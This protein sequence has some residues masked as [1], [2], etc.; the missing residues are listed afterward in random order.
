MYKFRYK[1]FIRKALIMCL[2]LTLAVSFACIC[3]AANL[4]IISFNKRNAATSDPPPIGEGL[5][6]GV[7]D[8]IDGVESGANDIIDGVESGANDIIDGDGFDTNIPDSNI[9]G[10][11][12]DDDSDGISNPTDPDDDNDGIPDAL[13]SDADNDGIID[14]EDPDP[15]GDGVDESKLTG[16]VVGIIIIILA[17]C[18]IAILVYALMPKK[19]H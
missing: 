2:S 18:A 16:A 13:D 14:D 10:A 7:N 4:N 6:S 11:V 19:K 17:A 9:G 1:K 8:I 5:E 3:S 12:K 15:D